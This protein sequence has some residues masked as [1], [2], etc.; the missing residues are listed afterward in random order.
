MEESV[1]VGTVSTASGAC[2]Q[3]QHNYKSIFL[4]NDL[5]NARIIFTVQLITSAG[6]S[7]YSIVDQLFAKCELQK[8]FV[9]RIDGV[10]DRNYQSMAPKSS[11]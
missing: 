8:D 1:V 2:R 4:Q 10:V 7:I 11:C 6:K 9:I 5:P 3:S